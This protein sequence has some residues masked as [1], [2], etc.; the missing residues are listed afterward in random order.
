MASQLQGVKKRDFWFLTIGQFQLF[1]SFFMFFQFPLFIKAVGGGER[2]I[3]VVMGFSMLLPAVLLPVTASLVGRLERKRLMLIGASGLAVSSVSAMVLVAPDIWMISLMTLRSVFFTLYMISSGAF[4]AS[5]I[6]AGERSK[7]MGIYF[8]FNQIATAVGPGLG[9]YLI[10]NYG[11]T[12]FFIASFGFVATGQMFMLAISTQTP[13]KPEK[14]FSPLW[15]SVS[16]L[17]E[18]WDRRFRYI[19]LTIVFMGMGLTSVFSFTATYLHLLGL[20][21]GVF[22]ATYAAINGG[23]RIF[24]GGLSDRFGRS[25]IVIP[26]LAMFVV[27]LIV[28]SYTTDIPWLI[29][30]ALAVGLGFGLANPTLSAQMIDR[31]PPHLYGVA[32]G[33]FHFAFNVG[34]MFSNPALGLVAEQISYRVMFQAAAVA[35]VIG[36]G[37]YILWERKPHKELL[38]TGE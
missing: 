12:S 30:S 33:G 10:L 8:G 28:Y 23:A 24:G 21:S 2:E 14:P 25:T 6:P 29:A 22:F 7:W 37:I 38:Y 17:V 4:V 20:S 36:L 16:F 5:I 31:A 32:V 18:L 19:F 13:K 11:F 1:C 26:S 15:D 35:A 27:G 9:E 34:N 3:G